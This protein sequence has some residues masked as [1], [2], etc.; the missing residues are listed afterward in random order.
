MKVFLP[1]R[2]SLLRA[3]WLAGALLAGAV[4]A[5]CKGGEPRAARSP[6]T[7]GVLRS[8]PFRDGS[9]ACRSTSTA[10]PCATCSGLSAAPDLGTLG[11]QSTYA[12]F[13][14]ETLTVDPQLA[15]NVNE[16]LRQTL[17]TVD[18]RQLAACKSGEDDTACA[19]RFASSFGAARVSP[20]DEQHGDDRAHERL[21]RGSTGELRGRDQPDGA[22]AAAVAVFHVPIR[23]GQGHAQRHRHHQPAIPTRSRLSSRT[24]SSTRRP[25]RI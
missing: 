4:T 7:T 14:D 15:F 17:E 6:A 9:G 11:G 8:I 19:T 12:F 1:S 13:A 5:G 24:P 25:T 3:A 22:G 2:L 21:R 10:T 18:V 16:T 23:A 20:S